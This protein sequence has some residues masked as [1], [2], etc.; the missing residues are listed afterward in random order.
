[1]VIETV[2]KKVAALIKIGFIGGGMMAQIG[3]LPFYL[4]DLRVEV[5]AV[6]EERPSLREALSTK[7]GVDRLLPSREALLSRPDIDAVVISSPR[8]ATGPLTL[9]ALSAGKHVLAEKPMAHSVA[10]ARRLVEAARE[11]KL[12]YAVGYMK[13]FDPG[14]VAAKAALDEIRTS[15]RLGRLL[16]ARVYDFSKSYAFPVPPHTRPSDSRAERYP[17]WPTYPDWLEER[18][19]AA[20]AWFLNSASHDVSLMR[21]LLSGPVSVTGA[22]S[23]SDGAVSALLQVG[24]VPVHL[25]IAKA[26]AGRWLEG[27]EFLFEAGRLALS[28]PSPMATDEVTHVTID[29]LRLG[30]VG[31]AL[32]TGTG[33]SFERQAKGFVDSLV[34]G[35]V[36]VASGEAALGDMELIEAIWRNIH[37]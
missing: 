4:A 26:D 15:G 33:W 25:E 6:V 17:V 28:I 9:E 35:H 36:N 24:D 11:R 1:V 34:A 16:S 18:Y 22:A 19:R 12:I 8:P 10:Q 14:V 13:L 5:A 7:L 2:P 27:A 20:Y 30:L 37:G 29:D 32:E 31:E 21:H 23:P 3:H